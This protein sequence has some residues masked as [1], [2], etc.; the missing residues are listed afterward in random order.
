MAANDRQVGGDHYKRGKEAGGEEH[1]DRVVSHQLD[2]FQAQITSYVERCWEKMGIQDL[3]KAGHYIEKYIEVSRAKGRKGRLQ[4]E[5]E[6]ERARLDLVLKYL[7]TEDGTFTF[8][9]GLCVP[10]QR[11]GF[12]QQID[13]RSNAFYNFEGVK[14]GYVTYTCRRCNTTFQVRV[15]KRPEDVHPYSVSGGTCAHLA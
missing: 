9:D 12:R 13:H 5:L 3:E 14:E 10:C 15:D 1:W 4:E 8:P 6:M 7:E 2:Y 11:I